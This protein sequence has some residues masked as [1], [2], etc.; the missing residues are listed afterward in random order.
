MLTIVS[1]LPSPPRAIAASM[2]AVALQV[3]TGGDATREYYEARGFKGYAPVGYDVPTSTI[4]DIADRTPAQNLTRI[5][6]ILKP[7]VKDLAGM[8][9][10][11][12]QAVYDWQGGG[13][14]ASRHADR[15][16]ELAN[17]ADLFA[18][19][20]VSITPQVLRRSLSAGRSFFDIVENGGLATIAARSLIG[21][22]RREAEQRR[23][24]DER[25]GNRPRPSLL[26]EEF[27]APML[28]EQG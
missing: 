11:S 13:A 25:L 24:L 2:L 23:V 16:A 20:G 6:A 18:A 22:I 7:S 19:E 8:I 10:V 5:R 28:D 15:L 3:G 4:A 27:G 12:R 26:T 1:Y 9:G 21:I 14:I 17:A